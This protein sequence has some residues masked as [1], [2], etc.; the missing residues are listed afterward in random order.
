MSTRAGVSQASA[1]GDPRRRQL[2]EAALSTF[3]R[4]GFRKTFHGRIARAA[5]VSRQGLYLH[6]STK[7]ELFRAGAEFAF[8]QALQTAKACLENPELDL[9]AR[10]V[11]ALDA[12]LGQY[13]GVAASENDLF[14]AS[15]R[16]IRPM[17]E[18]YEERFSDTLTKAVRSSAPRGGTP[19]LGPRRASARRHLAGRGARPQVQRRLEERLRARRHARGAGAVHAPERRRMTRKKASKSRTAWQGFALLG[20]LLLLFLGVVVVDGWRAFG[21]RAEGAR[22]ERMQAFT[23]MAG[24]TVREPGAD[25]RRRLG[26]AGGDVP[27]ELP[28]ESRNASA[29]GDARPRAIED[30]TGESACGDLVRTLFD[31]DRDRREADPHQIR[32][33]ASEPPLSPGLAPYAGSGRPSRSTTCRPS[34]RSSSRTITTITWTTPRS[35]R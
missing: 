25:G 8:S 22:L 19:C 4:F 29:G 18:E 1:E 13:V 32:C 34:T 3:V 20:V 26:N 5:Q 10:L 6:F 23:P 9:E 16:L 12:W 14:E 31:V 2:L 27:C 35:A 7:E 17:I 15:Q 11:G 30:R 24:R 28:R 33:G 21:H